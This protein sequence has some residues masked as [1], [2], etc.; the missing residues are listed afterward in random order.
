MLNF[1][2]NGVQFDDHNLKIAAEYIKAKQAES[3]AQSQEPQKSLWQLFTES[4]HFNFVVLIL[5]VTTLMLVSYM[6]P[7]FVAKKLPNIN[8][9]FAHV[10]MKVSFAALTVFSAILVKDTIYYLLENIFYVFIRRNGNNA[11][12]YQESLKNLSTWQ[13]MIITTLKDIVYFLGFILAYWAQ[14]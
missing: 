9:E 13:R 10:L 3:E 8:Q 12:D 4:R 1:E 6:V 7:S 2:F 11:F 5:M 14:L